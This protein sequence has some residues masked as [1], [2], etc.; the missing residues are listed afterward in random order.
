MNYKT[1]KKQL[2]KVFKECYKD[3]QIEIEKGKNND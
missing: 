3:S 1:F 2:A